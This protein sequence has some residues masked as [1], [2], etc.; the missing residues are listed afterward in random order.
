M[1]ILA[2]RTIDPDQ[3]SILDLVTDTKTPLGQLHAADF[4]SACFEVGRANGGWVH[5]SKVSRLLHLAFG[6]INPR[7]FSGMWGSSCGR[8][9]FMH[10]TEIPEPIDPEF[11][12]G[13]GAKDVKL[14]R[15][16]ASP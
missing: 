15:L 8:N 13:N 11:S 7:W 16:R 10:K 6:E 4:R 12:R 5:P 9:G 3:L 2:A 14:R 1:T